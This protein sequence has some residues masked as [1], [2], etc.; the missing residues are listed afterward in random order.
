MHVQLPGL[1]PGWLLGRR[2]DL[3]DAQWRDFRDALPMLSAA[4]I[5]FLVLSHAVGFRWLLCSHMDQIVMV[6]SW[7]CGAH[8]RS[9]GERP[10]NVPCGTLRGI[11]V[12]GCNRRGHVACMGH[13]Q[14]AMALLNIYQC[15]SA[16]HGLCAG[17]A[18]RTYLTKPSDALLCHLL[19]GL[20]RYRL[21]TLVVLQSSPTRCGDVQF[22]WENCT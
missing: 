15:D 2:V 3:S 1:R 6:V 12:D 16:V 10:G 7:G 8:M 14:R 4:M 13:L 11:G 19:N 21:Q 9:H 17:Q 5:G 20:P 22:K 18:E